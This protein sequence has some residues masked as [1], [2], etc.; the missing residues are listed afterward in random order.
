MTKYHELTVAKRLKLNESSKPEKRACDESRISDQEWRLIKKSFL[1]AGTF[2]L[3]WINYVLICIY[4]LS[5]SHTIP[6]WIDFAWESITGLNPL[7][8]CLIL[9]TYDGKVRQNVRELLH[10][11][12]IEGIL[13]KR[14]QSCN[15]WLTANFRD[16]HHSKQEKANQDKIYQVNG[17]PVLLLH[18]NQGVRG[19]TPTQ[20]DTI[21]IPGRGAPPATPI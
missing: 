2:T 12:A 4:E 14:W 21:L 19:S 13:G 7:V 11:E 5:T 3:T 8:N 1:I 6:L 9:Y 15:S 16:N 20:L 18:F 10:A 17:N